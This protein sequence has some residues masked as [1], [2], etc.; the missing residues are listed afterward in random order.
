MKN[1]APKSKISLTTSQVVLRIVTIISS[2]EFLIM[3]FLGTY[4]LNTNIYSQATLDLILLASF[5]TPLIYILVIKPFVTARDDALAHISY[6]AHT[7]SLTQL[8]NRRL[9]S[10]HLEKHLASTIRHKIRGAFLLMDLDGFKEINDVHGHDAGD[11]VLVEVAKRIQ[12]N[13]R[14]EDVTCRLGGDEFVI[15]IQHLDTDEEVARNTTGLFAKKLV[16]AIN[17]PI[18]FNHTTLTITASIGV[19]LLD[20]EEQDTKSVIRE[21]DS[22]MYHAKQAGGDRA[23][24]FEKIKI[25]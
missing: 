15:L 14:S 23:V 9:L 1:P 21:A 20:F 4:P 7:D 8:P 13:T 3:L 22:A 17:Q 12:S 2:V 19:R 24:F 25:N 5:S 11:V 18:Q 10:I 6:L 16:D